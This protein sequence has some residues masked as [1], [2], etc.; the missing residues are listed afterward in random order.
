MSIKP[1]TLTLKALCDH[2]KITTPAGHENLELS[3]IKTLHEAGAS[4]LSFFDNQQYKHGARSTQA[5]AVLVRER[6]ASVLPEG[7]VAVLTN[8]PYMAFAQALQF[9]YPEPKP[10]AGISQ[11]AVV[12]ASATVHPTARI[13]PY[14]VVYANANIGPH[15]HIG[16]HAVVGEGVV[17]GEGTRIG[18]HVTLQKTTIGQ[19][20]ILH[21]GVRIG[22]D[23][24]GFAVGPTER[25]IGIVKVPQIGSVQIGNEV[26]IGANTTIDCGALGDTVILDMAKIDNQVQIGHNAKIGFGARIVSQVGVAGSSTLG[27]FTVIGGQ[28]GIAGHLN[29]ADK[30]MVAARSGVTKSLTTSGEVVA[31]TPAVP[32]KEWRRSI[33]TLARL[34]KMVKTKVEDGGEEGGE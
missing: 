30:V 19:N 7:T 5:G 11:F 15:V 2:L 1:R 17:I 6:D 22:Q 16:A 25:G 29:I 12:S 21:P 28:S 32:I 13:E 31:G 3:A 9:M 10:D 8:Q 24:F 34:T 33:A 20:C 14:A 26:E 23:G 27:T 18:A 4:D